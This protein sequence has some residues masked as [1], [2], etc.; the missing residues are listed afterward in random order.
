MRTA[1]TA[2]SNRSKADQEPATWLPSAKAY[3]CEYLA[4]RVA[5]KLRWRLS[6]DDVERQALTDGMADC[7]NKPVKVTLAR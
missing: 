2:R 1:V 4:D 7:P 5:V 3:W 6:V